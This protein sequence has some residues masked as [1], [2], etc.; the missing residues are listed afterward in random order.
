MK[1]GANVEA[2]SPETRDV[3]RAPLLALSR[4]RYWSPLVAWTSLGQSSLG[5]RLEGEDPIGHHRWSLSLQ[6]DPEGATVQ[7]IPDVSMSYRYGGLPINISA[8]LVR[9]AI[10]SG[11]FDGADVRVQ[12]TQ[13][14]L[15]RLTV[16]RALRGLDATDGL[17]LGLTVVHTDAALRGRWADP[18]SQVPLLLR[19]QFQPIISGMW[20]HTGSLGTHFGT[21]PEYGWNTGLV[22]SVRARYER[23]E[24][25]ALGLCAGRCPFRSS[26]R[27]VLTG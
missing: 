18:A 1:G 2:S 24:L 3:E 23:A 14:T 10:S 22:H 5:V 17:S 21:S 9:A 7:R 26:C 27:D 11:W 4:P 15:G 6:L 13:L 19:P 25:G 12:N 20:S 8:G 16:S